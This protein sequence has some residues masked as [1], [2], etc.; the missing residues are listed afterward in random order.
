LGDEHHSSLGG[1]RRAPVAPA[2]AALA[3]AACTT[4]PAV[5][6]APTFAADVGPIFKAHCVR[7]HGAQDMLSGEIID[8][9]ASRA[10]VSCYLDRMEDRG[11]CSPVDGGPPDRMLC[12]RGAAYCAAAMS[13]D[14][15]SLLDIYLFELAGTAARMPPPP[16]AELNDWEMEVVRLWEAAGA[17][18]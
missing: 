7:C 11:D 12:K 6:G 9:G 13:G 10:P 1:G 14:T 8:G 18:P 5:P 16:A 15:R 3:L 2:L 17:R 4:Y